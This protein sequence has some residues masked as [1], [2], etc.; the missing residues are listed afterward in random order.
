[1]ASLS[2]RDEKRVARGLPTMEQMRI[3]RSYVE[4]AE[5]IRSRLGKQFRVGHSYVTPSH[6]LEAGDTKKWFQQVVET[7]IGPLLDEYW[8][9]APDEAQKAFARLLQGW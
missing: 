5:I 1:M 7:E 3:W 6:R 4:T 8:F 2:E 9:D